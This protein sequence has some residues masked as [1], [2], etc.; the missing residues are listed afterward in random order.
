M[1]YHPVNPEASIKD[2]LSGVPYRVAY[3]SLSIPLLTN[4]RKLLR[5]KLF[6]AMK[7]Q[8]HKLR[9]LRESIHKLGK[10]T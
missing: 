1:F 8:K 5:F 3:G 10:K 9:D 2:Y 7:D 4:H 6:N